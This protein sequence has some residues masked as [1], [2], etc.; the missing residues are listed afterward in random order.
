MIFVDNPNPLNLRKRINSVCGVNPNNEIEEWLN[1][2]PI[3]TGH[4]REHTLEEL[5]YS[6][7]Q[8]GFSALKTGGINFILK[9]YLGNAFWLRKIFIYLYRLLLIT[10]SLKDTLYIIGKKSS[11]LTNVPASL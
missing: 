1:Q 11:H 7:E 6:A 3:F 2:Q 9:G 5:V 8:S 4:Y 10:D